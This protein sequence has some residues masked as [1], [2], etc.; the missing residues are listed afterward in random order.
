MSPNRDALLRKLGYRFKEP[1]LL[2]Q[3][4]THRSVGGQHNE[5]LEYLGD[6]VLGFLIAQELYQRHPRATEGELSRMRA[7]LVRGQTIAS[8]A[9]SAL[10]LGPFLLLGPGELKS[11]GVRRE[12]ILAGAFEA[13]LG[14]VF[15]DG[16]VEAC[17]E[18]VMRLWA[19]AL[20]GCTPETVAKDPKTQLQEYLQARKLPLP[21]Y[22]TVVVGGAEH[23]QTFT[24]SCQV[25]GM[26]EAVLGTGSSR[27]NAEQMAAQLALEKLSSE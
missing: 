13:I 15:L 9:T 6:A 21:A 4:I 14:A 25:D 7:G 10:D 20:A 17:R 5:R 24:V 3:A 16:G 27:R 23:A 26:T 11:G 8:L 1:A 22:Q 18:L 19:S 2:Q 12:S